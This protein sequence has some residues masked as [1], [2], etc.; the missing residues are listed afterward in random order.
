MTARIFSWEVDSYGFVPVP[1]GDDGL[2]LIGKMRSLPD[3]WQA[4]IWRRAISQPS[5]DIKSRK[6]TSEVTEAWECLAEDFD[7]KHEGP[8]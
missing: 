3:D 6:F 4:D 2:S 7:P 1:D 8:F 5:F